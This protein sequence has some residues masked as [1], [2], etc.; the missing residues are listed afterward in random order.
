MPALGSVTS[1]LRSEVEYW[2]RVH[3]SSQVSIYI[4][5]TPMHRTM[6]NLV[7]L[8]MNH[9]NAFGYQT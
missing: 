8:A 7:V 4:S 1:V 2:D 3:S 9:C 5:F 6:A